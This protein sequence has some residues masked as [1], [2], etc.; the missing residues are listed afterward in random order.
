M[1]G[2]SKPQVQ[3]KR[4]EKH[5]DLTGNNSVLIKEMRPGEWEEGRSQ[6]SSAYSA[7]KCTFSLTTLTSR[8]GQDGGRLLRKARQLSKQ[9]QF[10]PKASLQGSE[11]GK[12]RPQ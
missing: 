11:D 6:K 1:G 5:T 10:R 9:R 12:E 4:D 2:E 3:R 8:L 7:K